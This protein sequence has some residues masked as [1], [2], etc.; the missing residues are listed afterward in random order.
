MRRDF[1]AAVHDVVFC[2]NFGTNYIS[3]I[4]KMGMPGRL[5]EREIAEISL[6][7]LGIISEVVV[8]RKICKTT[9]GHCKA[10]TH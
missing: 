5:D 10:M 3:K 4:A 1:A 2:L 9:I 7:L 8:N 6:F